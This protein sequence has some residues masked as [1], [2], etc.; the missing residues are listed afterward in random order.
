[1]VFMKKSI[2]HLSKEKQE[3]ILYLVSRIQ[4]FIPQAE[5]IILYGSYATGNYVEYDER[6][7]FGV[8]T[9]YMSDYD[10]LVVIGD[11]SYKP[12]QQ[13]L[14]NIEASYY[15]NP[16]TQT[17]VQFIQE[18]IKSLNRQL[19]EGR[20]FYTQL[21]KEGIVLYDSGNFKLARRRKLN[22]KEVQQQA[23]EY[24]DVKFK[25]ADF[26][27]DDAK[28]NYQKERYKRA[29]FYLHQACE[30][31]YHAIRLSFTL[32]NPKQHN[33]SKLSTAIRRYSKELT[34]VFPC[35]TEEE[36]RLFELVKAA[37]VEARYNTKFIVTKEDIETLVPKVELLR[38]IT[39]HICEQ[40]I[41]EYGQMEN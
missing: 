24:F 28:I 11:G 34:F 30:N 25:E 15:K 16:D 14:D 13:S 5:M 4:K 18:N 31:Y 3:D 17:P 20:Y 1:M 2:S 32:R 27:F 12:V 41:E 38:D 37:Y 7:E 6:I 29:S 19:E 8:P 26:F 40:K 23:Q 9:S 21:K 36:K 10:I 35:N 33:L 39:K 22:Y